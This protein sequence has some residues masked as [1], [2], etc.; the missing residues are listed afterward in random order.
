MGSLFPFNCEKIEL[1]MMSCQIITRF[2]E[3]MEE[4]MQCLQ[5]AFLFFNFS[6]LW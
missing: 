4:L 1:L 3:V 6:W 2:F 5:A